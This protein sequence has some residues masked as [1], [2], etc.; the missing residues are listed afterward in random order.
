MSACWSG[1]DL[2]ARLLHE[3][4]APEGAFTSRKEIQMRT[5]RIVSVALSAILWTA[6]HSSEAQAQVSTWHSCSGSEPAADEVY[7]Y[8]DASFG[9]SCAALY[10]GFYPLPGTGSGEFGL[11]NDSISSIKV[12]SDVR[13]RLFADATYDGS[14]TIMTSGDYSTPP[15]GWNDTVSS[16]RVEDGSRSTTCSDLVAGEFA[17]FRDADEGSDCVVLQY[18]SNYPT[19]SDMGIANDSISSIAPGPTYEADCGPD[20]AGSYDV[21]L[22][23]DVDYGGTGFNV[24]SGGADEDLNTFNDVTSSITTFAICLG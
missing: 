18:G 17:V 16:I 3:A 13:A 24:G 2:D 1:A 10:V 15:T 6:L 7:I 9:G 23:S 12:G 14:F 11:P 19:P 5:A 22:Y 21:E 4:A 8:V 20:E